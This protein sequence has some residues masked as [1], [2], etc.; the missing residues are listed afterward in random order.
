MKQKRSLNYLQD[1]LD[2]AGNKTFCFLPC[3]VGNFDGI[4]FQFG[5]LKDTYFLLPEISMT[6]HYRELA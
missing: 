2:G 3:M 6:F 5:V 4:S 1:K